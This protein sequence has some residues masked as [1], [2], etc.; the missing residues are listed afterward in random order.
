MIW[1]ERSCFSGLNLNHVPLVIC[2]VQFPDPD[3]LLQ[4]VLDHVEGSEGDDFGQTGF[5]HVDIYAD[6]ITEIKCKV[7]LSFVWRDK[8]LSIYAMHPTL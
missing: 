4:T 1:P 6:V 3:G 7:K 8:D 2:R 5:A